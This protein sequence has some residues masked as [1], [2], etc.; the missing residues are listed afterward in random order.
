MEDAIDA[1]S[2]ITELFGWIGIGA[3]FVLLAIG[4]L[5]GAFYRGWRET[6]G[7]VVLDPQGDLVY[8]WLGEDG[9]LYEAPAADDET[10]SLEPGD[11]VTVQ[12][13][14]RDRPAVVSTTH[15]TRGGRCAP[16]AGSCLGSGRSRS[17]CSSC[18]CSCELLTSH[19]F[20]ASVVV[21]ST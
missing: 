10:Q 12:V 13:S 5:R 8:R 18:C 9:L 1:V 6:L 16:R 21:V 15:G 14:P 3:G 19:L 20:F 4:F 7:V 2:L 17:S 11:E